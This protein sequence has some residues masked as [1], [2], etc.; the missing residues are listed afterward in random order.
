[1]GRTV[2]QEARKKGELLIVDDADHNDLGGL[3]RFLYWEWLERA[4]K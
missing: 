2:F 3:E 1:M 4:L